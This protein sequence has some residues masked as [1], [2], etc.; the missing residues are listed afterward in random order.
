M[1]LQGLY[2][3]VDPGL[4][5]NSQDLIET[6]EEAIEGG[7]AILQLRDKN[8][9]DGLLYERA[10]GLAR[11]CSER[12]VLFVVN[13]RLD[14]A[15]CSGAH[16]V[17]LGAEDLPVSV[18]RRL[19]PTNFVIG[20][21]AG[22]LKRARQ[23]ESEGANYLGVG[24]LYEARASKAD[25]SAPKGTKIIAEVSSNVGIPVFGIGGINAVN[26]ADVIAAGASGVAVIR[27]IFGSPS[28]G[29]AA[30]ELG[31]AIDR[32]RTLRQTR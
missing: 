13:N 8:S 10:L 24:A 14:I 18:A 29:D 12:D 32:G 9:P 19:S 15:L 6:V 3:I 17:H 2:G 22:T 4:L 27:A 25:A 11:I 1:I 20:A 21:S 30:R 7:V 31:L 5:D 16:G 26:T 28:P 23:M